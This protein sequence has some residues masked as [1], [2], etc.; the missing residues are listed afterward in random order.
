MVLHV[1]MKGCADNPLRINESR[2]VPFSFFG[3]GAGRRCDKLVSAASLAMGEHADIETGIHGPLHSIGDRDQNRAIFQHT[4]ERAT[5][6]PPSLP[7]LARHPT[8]TTWRFMRSTLP[9]ACRCILPIIVCIEFGCGC[10]STVP[11]GMANL[12]SPSWLA[13]RESGPLS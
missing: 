12:R 4:T 1:S 6:P 7:L 9:V 13:C 2:G 3:G 5:P 8:G 10:I 11:T